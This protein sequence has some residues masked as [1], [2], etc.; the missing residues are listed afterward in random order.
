MPFDIPDTETLVK[1]A[2][3]AFRANMRG[4]DGMLF[5]NNI[6]VSSKVIGGAI[7][8]TFKFLDYISK[9]H[10]IHLSEGI[11]LERHAFD[12]GL[13]RAAPTFAEGFVDLAGGA[14]QAIPAGTQLQ[15]ADGTVYEVTTASATNNSGNATGVPVRALVAGKAG[16]ALSGVGLTLVAPV[17]NISDVGVVNTAGIGGGADIESDASLM[18][19]VLFRRRNKPR[20]GAKHDYVDWAREVNGI[21]RVFVDPITATNNRLS[22]G[23]W[24]LMDSTYANGIAQQADV[25]IVQAYIDAVKP[26]GAVVAV[27]TPVATPINLTIANLAD[28]SVLTK[29]AIAVELAAFFQRQAVS[30]LTDPVTLYRS[31]LIEAISAATGEAHHTLSVPATDTVIANGH[32]ATLGTITWA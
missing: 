24:I 17:A 23:V 25:D 32:V 1:R 15:R 4:S 7:D 14:A 13:A 27:G 31:Q 16:N 8:E 6:A 30:T 28:N 3:A 20:G 2:A 9:Q 18:S 22:V 11:W 12:Y 5:P 26:A 10:I 29:N 19:R 21:T